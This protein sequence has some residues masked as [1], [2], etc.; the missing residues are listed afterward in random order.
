MTVLG[1][2]PGIS[3]C[4]LALVEERG[5]KIHLTFA[6][7]IRTRARDET[8]DTDESQR[9]YEL[10]QMCHLTVSDL[11]P[12]EAAVEQLIFARNRLTAIRVAQARGTLLTL[13]GKLG[14][15]VFSYSPRDIKKTLTGYGAA[16]K[17]QVQFCVQQQLGLT[18][19]LP[20]DAADA[21]AVALCHLR[22]RRLIQLLPKKTRVSAG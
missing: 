8:S 19:R 18:K 12:Q 9:L 15:P 6:D 5:K 4:G 22:R 7:V 13:L 14:V 1:I 3:A 10:F 16:Q 17:H 20:K 2:D 21:A 11:S